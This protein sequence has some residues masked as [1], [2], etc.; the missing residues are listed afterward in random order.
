M[1][2]LAICIGPL[3][4]LLAACDFPRPRD[5]P[6]PDADVADDAG[7]D[8]PP[9]IG[10]IS[11]C[12]ANEFI[13]CEA[14]VARTCNAT[15][16]GTLTQD[17]GVA[18]CNADAK[19]CNQ[20]VPNTDSCSISANEL[21]HCG[22]DGLRG[23]PEVCLLG[24]KTT[25]AAHCAYLE[26]RYLPDIC[27]TPA[28]NGDREVNSPV[29]IDTSVD[30]DCTG[31]IVMQIGAPDICVIRHGSIHVTAGGTL[32]ASG[33]RA[34][35]LVADRALDIAGVLDVSANGIGSGPGGGT[36]ASGE[37]AGSDIGG[38]GA[39]FGTAGGNGGSATVDGGGGRGGAQAMNPALL[40]VL[41]GGT[42]PT[43]TLV[44]RAPQAGG[45][46]GAAT[47]IACRGRISVTGTID[48]GGGGGSGGKS[49]VFAG[50]FWAGAGAGSGGNVVFQGLSVSV[51]GQMFANGG[52]GGAGWLRSSARTGLTQ[53]APR[54]YRRQVA[55]RSQ[56]KV[57]EVPA[58]A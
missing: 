15:G 50:E 42:R 9:D 46:G 39:G 53:Y 19:R 52:G 43:R 24:C 10:V 48:A 2:T 20:C 38:G 56:A 16:D 45:A 4:W 30:S 35:A 32:T 6:G 29:T 14:N 57:R 36:V 1:R 17:C 8:A 55:S 13:A 23:I 51:T 28:T 41:V 18:G 21:D 37:R 11:S 26:P 25:P 34:L 44:A 40:T 27:D 31:G 58:G 54:R 47:L 49:G 7:L 5:V 12:P 3:L 22:A 33:S